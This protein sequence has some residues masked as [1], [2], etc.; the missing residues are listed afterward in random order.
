M[1]GPYEC[2]NELSGSIKFWE[3]LEP[4]QN[5]QL[6]KMGKLHGVIL[7][8]LLV[9]SRRLHVLLYFCHVDRRSIYF[10]S[11]QPS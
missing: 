5:C 7:D 11:F 4:L 1:E 3:V 10:T 2:G 8:N 9:L 6:P